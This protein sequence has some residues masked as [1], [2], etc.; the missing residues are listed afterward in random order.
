MNQTVIPC[1]R[2]TSMGLHTRMRILIW[3]RYWGELTQVWLTLLCEIV[4][5][6]VTD[7]KKQE[8]TGMNLYQN[9]SHTGVM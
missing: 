6:H 8:G 4:P 9:E 3:Y 2:D 1:L 7:T 5:N